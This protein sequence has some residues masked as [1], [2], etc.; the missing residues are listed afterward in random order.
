MSKKPESK[1]CNKVHEAFDSY[2]ANVYPRGYSPEQYGQVK[3]AFFAGALCCSGE[4]L[5]AQC[6]DV[7]GSVENVTALC[8]EISDECAALAT[9]AME[10]AAKEAA[11]RN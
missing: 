6:E 10:N 8:G 9:T 2:L 7:E 4:L 3:M 11:K 1:K 5:E